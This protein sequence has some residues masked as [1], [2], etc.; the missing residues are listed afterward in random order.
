MR[1]RGTGF[2]PIRCGADSWRA[3][4]R[5]PYRDVYAGFL[6]KYAYNTVVRPIVEKWKGDLLLKNEELVTESRRKFERRPSM[7]E[8]LAQRLRLQR[9]VRHRLVPSSIRVDKSRTMLFLT[10]PAPPPPLSRPAAS[11]LLQNA[12]LQE[13]AAL[14]SASPSARTGEARELV[15]SG[16]AEFIRVYTPST[17][18]TFGTDRVV[19]GRR[20]VRITDMIPVGNYALRISF[21]DKHDA[22]IYA[23]DY[24]YH[25]T[26]PEHKYRLM[27]EYIRELRSQRKSRDPPRRRASEKRFEKET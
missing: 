11:S 10:W 5:F 13:P 2:S 18:G 24:L 17:D 20:G 6:D 22:G 3:S 7:S 26:C 14:A 15:T 25:L 12:K 23:Y 27:R 16:L 19:Y 21:S 1:C 4:L 8:S 9:E